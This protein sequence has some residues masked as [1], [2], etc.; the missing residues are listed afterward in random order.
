MV[1]MTE[2]RARRLEEA[3]AAEDAADARMFD[4]RVAEL[5]ADDVPEL[6]DPENPEW[7]EADFARARPASEVLNIV[8]AAID[9][10]DEDY[11]RVMAGLDEAKVIIEREAGADS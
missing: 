9:I 1:Q 5:A 10:G 11:N 2:T 6:G 3:E 8:P 7:S 4:E